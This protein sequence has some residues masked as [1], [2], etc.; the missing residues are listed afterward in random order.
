MSVKSG[1]SAEPESS[2]LLL[3]SSCSALAVHSCLGTPFAKIFSWLTVGTTNVRFRHSAEFL[4]FRKHFMCLH[5]AYAL[6]SFSAVLVAMLY[7]LL[8]AARTPHSHSVLFS[9]A[10]S[11]SSFNCNFSVVSS[12]LVLVTSSAAFW[13]A[14]LA[15]TYAAS[16]QNR[17]H[18]DSSS[19]FRGYVPKLTP[20]F[21]S[22]VASSVLV[23]SVV[24][25]VLTSSVVF[26]TWI[27]PLSLQSEPS[28]RLPICASNIFT[29]S[30][31]ASQR[32]SA[33][34]S[35]SSCFFPCWSMVVISS[36]TAAAVLAAAAAAFLAA[37][38]IA[39]VVFAT[40]AFTLEVAE[41]AA[42]VKA[43]VAAGSRFSETIVST[44][45][46]SADASSL[47]C[48]FVTIASNPRFQSAEAVAATTVEARAARS[49]KSDR[50]RTM[51]SLVCFPMYSALIP[52]H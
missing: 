15:V 38:V 27:C 29:C 49:S 1:S 10:R 5:L 3:S 36:F 44:S 2:S 11:M 34:F 33:S 13:D 18:S 24:S 30:E 31:T 21:A 45:W 8:Y 46:T 35:H 43:A 17:P 9:S 41:P 19:V 22:L 48:S 51:L 23:L 6:A 32:S 47:V 52:P 26:L 25:H 7:R 42:A 20:A 28:E 39:A 50:E 14:C 12:M 37:V 40:A 4:V 16:F